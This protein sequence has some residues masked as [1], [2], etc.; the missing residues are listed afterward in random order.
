M[1]SPLP[2]RFLAPRPMPKGNRDRKAADLESIAL[3]VEDWIANL[4][5]EDEKQFYREVVR[6]YR[7]AAREISAKSVVK[8][9][10]PEH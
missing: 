10:R 3:L 1:S 4:K 5:N 6:S 8:R 9:S 7:A 2:I